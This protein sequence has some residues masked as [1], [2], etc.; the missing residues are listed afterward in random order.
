VFSTAVVV[1]VVLVS[2]AAGYALGRGQ[3]PGKKT[4]VAALVVTMFLP[5]G[6]T[7]I[8]IFVLIGELGL[9]NTLAGV[10][11][12]QAGPAHIIAILLF[13]GF[14]ANLPDELEEAAIMDGANHLQIYSRIMLPLAKPVIGT[15][16]LFNFIGAWNEFLVPLVFTLS[17]PDLRTLGV[18][19]YHFVGVDSTDWPALAAAA[20]ITVIPV[21]VVFLWLQRMFIEG[22][23]GAVK[24]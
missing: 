5:K 1:I 18:G 23:A 11:L 14:F 20:C 17:R 6:Y 9:Q 21:I 2:S 24:G 12:A 10:V 22:I 13:M 19:M 3:L 7:I 8:P 4:V 15:V 16:A